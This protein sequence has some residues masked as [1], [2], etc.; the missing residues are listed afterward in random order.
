MKSFLY[1]LTDKNRSIIHVDSSSD[2][3]RTISAIHQSKNL[4]FEPLSQANRLVYF[5]EYTNEA[6][7]FE[8]Q[9]QVKKFTKAQKEKLIR[10]LNPDWIDL[11]VGLQH[12]RVL[13]TKRFVTNVP[14][15]FSTN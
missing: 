2:L 3:L 9:K 14:M 4:F 12:E 1:F 11:S 8:R 13:H 7:L 15:Q 5:E 6:H 10:K